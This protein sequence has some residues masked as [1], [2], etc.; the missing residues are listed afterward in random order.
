MFQ[1][2][3]IYRIWIRVLVNNALGGKF[4]HIANGE[5]HP[6]ICNQYEAYFVINEWEF[7][8]FKK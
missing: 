2:F 6:N 7:D 8:G 1:V 4:Y 5:N 3:L